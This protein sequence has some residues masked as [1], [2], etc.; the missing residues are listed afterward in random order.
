MGVLS[1]KD[2]T[3]PLREYIQVLSPLTP[4]GTCMLSAKKKSL[5]V[6]VH[7][8]I[9]IM[10]TDLHASPRGPGNLEKLMLPCCGSPGGLFWAFVWACSCSLRAAMRTGELRVWGSSQAGS[11]NL[12]PPWAFLC[13]TSVG[14]PWNKG[15][16]CLRPHFVMVSPHIVVHTLSGCRLLACILDRL[17]VSLRILSI[18]LASLMTCGVSRL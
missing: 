14:T 18:L 6:G 13:P 9:N 11:L 15:A 7:A 4:A 16:T 8:C 10:R 17:Y 1:R 12:T 5:A 2:F 3:E